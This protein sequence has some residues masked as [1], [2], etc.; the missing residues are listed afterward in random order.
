M[1]RR[2]HITDKCLLALT[3]VALSLAG[4]LALIATMRGTTPVVRAGVLRSIAASS[5]TPDHSCYLPGSSNVYTLTVH[6]AST[7][8][9]WLDVVTCTFPGGWSVA[10]VATDTRDSCGN[11][12]NFSISSAVTNQVTFTDDDG[13]WGEV[14]EGC[15][16]NVIITVTVP[17][18]V[19]GQQT[20]SWALSGDDWENLSHDITGS[21]TLSTGLL[22]DSDTLRR[23]AIPGDDAFYT[24]TLH[25]HTGATQDIILTYSSTWPITGSTSLS[26]VASCT[27]VTLPVTVT[28][29]SGTLTGTVDVATVTASGGGYTS[30]VS[31]RTHACISPASVS[32]ASDSP[33]G[34]GQPMHF[35]AIVSPTD[36]TGP[37]AYEWDFGGPGNVSVTD[38]ATPVYTYTARN[39]YTVAV[40]VT[41]QCG[42]P[43]SA[44]LSVAVGARIYLPVV[45]RNYAP[46][47]TGPTN[48]PPYTPS[49]HTFQP[50]AF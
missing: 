33:V 40:T 12:V 36:A 30:T 47:G 24:L 23:G 10:S 16:W 20:V 2:K 5:V 15:S 34:L 6:N 46:P 35:T 44:A 41:G 19:T 25:N 18:S 7:D 45:M 43:A 21:F 31:L 13:G 29:P 9:E 4:V 22:F 42:D 8:L 14:H 17:V 49:K 11:H 39:N 37:F 26:S 38:T 27:S 32:L 28:V 50:H 48:H 3:L 1:H